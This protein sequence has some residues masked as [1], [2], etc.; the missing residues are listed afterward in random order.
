MKIT[1]SAAGHKLEAV[2]DVFQKG[3]HFAADKSSLNSLAEKLDSLDKEF[4]SIAYE[5]ASMNI[6]LNCLEVGTEIKPWFD[7]L[8]SAA[9][10][11]GIQYHIGL[12]WALAQLQ[13]NTMPY[14][15]QLDAIDRYRVPD[16]YGYYEAM[17]RTKRCIN[18][19]QKP[20]GF[21]EAGL[22]AYYQGLGRGIW[23]LSEG[24]Q[25][26][27][28][29]LIDKF[30]EENRTDLWRGLGIA[31]AYAGG[32]NVGML[33]QIMTIAGDYSR[34]LATGA[35]MVAICRERAGFMSADTDQACRIWCK[36]NAGELVLR[37][38]LID[39]S[40][41]TN[42]EDGYLNWIKGIESSF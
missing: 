27:A 29:M 7:F 14:M 42:E 3:F 4:L 12:G 8:G 13:L 33:K 10:A 30:T 28:K 18:N 41:K 16:G 24:E 17:F 31:C 34:Q 38:K 15:L 21:N 9:Q 39:T 6:A 37:H 40:I 25:E 32:C 20:E 1:A 36:E 26:A 5:G 19:Q 35:I 2:Q 11:H 22:S 23:Y